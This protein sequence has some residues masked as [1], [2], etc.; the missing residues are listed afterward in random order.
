MN[1]AQI[2]LLGEYIKV[3][4]EAILIE[5][6]PQNVIDNGAIILNSNCS[7]SE[8]MGYYDNFEYI[9][10]DWYNRLIESSKTHTPILI[11]KNIN[12][13]AQKEQRKF[14]ELFKYKKMYIHKLPK[15]CM[16]LVTYTNLQE[17]PIEEE[18]Y[19]FMVHI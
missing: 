2:D 16:I 1:K 8:L 10:P 17:N 4:K 18:L 19:S 5:E 14:I 9:T 12:E 13:I 7:N 11:I 15:N 3:G 6:I